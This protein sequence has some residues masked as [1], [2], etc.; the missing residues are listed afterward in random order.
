MPA[1]ENE[2][3][4]PRPALHYIQPVG[5]PGMPDGVRLP[6]PPDVTT[7]KPVKQNRDEKHAGF[8]NDSPGNLLQLARDVV[9]FTHAYQRVAVRPE[10]F[11]QECPNWYYA[12]EG[13]QF[14]EEITRLRI[15]RCNRHA[16]SKRVER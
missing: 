4:Q 9:V 16:H 15:S 12:A 10:M 5:H 1:D 7:V 6:R 11:G 3:N 2:S 8:D 14:V 13:L